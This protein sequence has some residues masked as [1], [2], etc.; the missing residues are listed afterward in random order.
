[1]K[2]LVLTAA[3]TV[4]SLGAVSAQSTTQQNPSQGTTTQNSQSGSDLGTTTATEAQKAEVTTMDTAKVTTAVDNTTASAQSDGN[5]D[6]TKPKD[7]ATKSKSKKK[8]K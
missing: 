8:S 1:M 6:A 5:S 3:F 2:K 7:E 4:L